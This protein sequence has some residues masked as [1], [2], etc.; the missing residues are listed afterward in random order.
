MTNIS[1]GLGV[2]EA[3]SMEIDRNLNYNVFEL[4]KRVID[5]RDSG[6]GT[7]LTKSLVVVVGLV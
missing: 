2:G 1:Y 6:R 7:R 5:D 3:I 4:R